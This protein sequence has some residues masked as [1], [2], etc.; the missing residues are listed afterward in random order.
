[1]YE[2][3]SAKHFFGLILLDIL[4][5]SIC[6]VFFF[7]GKKLLSSSADVNSEKSVFLPVIMYHSVFGGS[8]EEYIVTPVQFENDLAWL[9]KNGYT[10]VTAQ[11]L[12][13]YVNDKGN[14]PD[15]PVMITFDDGC[16]NNLSDVLP[17]LEKYDMHA[18]V[19][20]VGQYT[21][22]TAENDPHVPSYSYLTWDDINRLIASGRVEIG[23]HTYNMHSFK[24]NRNG[25]SKNPDESEEEYVSALTEDLNSLQSEI[26]EHTGTLPVVFA[27]PFGF[28][29]KESMPVIRELGFTITLTC[30][31]RPNHITRNPECLYGI[32]RYNRSG[33]YS[34]EEFMNK[35]FKE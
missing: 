8:P 11:Q 14:L 4:V 10:S 22:V 1:M 35:I 27:Y 13:D 6:S 23:N 24:G 18:I 33:F 32:N 15:K 17:L 20:V 19:S 21:D 28:I 12:T 29:S 5:F 9:V 2:C 7:T 16:Y 31:E 26:R 30:S 34:T 3:R 25:C